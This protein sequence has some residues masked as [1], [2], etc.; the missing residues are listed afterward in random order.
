MAGVLVARGVGRGDLV[1]VVLERSVDVVA[2]LLGIAKA[3]AG[4]VPVDP[5]YPV[6][7]IGWM[8]EDAGPV[9]VVCSEET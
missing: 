7:R 6:E 1:A 9:L 5:A 4:F 3:G 8:V 2:V